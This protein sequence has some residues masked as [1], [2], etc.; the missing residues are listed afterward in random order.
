MKNSVRNGSNIIMNPI[1]FKRLTA[2]YPAPAILVGLSVAQIIA[3]FQVYGS[4]SALYRT[5]KAVH[6]AGYVTVADQHT[7]SRLQELSTALCGGLFL[8][9]S[10]GAGICVLSFLAAWVWVRVFRRKTVSLIPILLI[11]AGLAACFNRGGFSLF[12]SLYVLLVPPVVFTGTLKWMP[13]GDGK[14]SLIIGFM[15]AIPIIV[16]GLLWAPQMDKALFYDIRDHLLRRNPI[17]EKIVDFYYRY[18]FYPAQALKPLDGKRFKTYRLDAGGKIH[19]R[20]ELR[21]KLF[22][23]GFIETEHA[24][25]VDLI[26]KGSV[27]EIFLADEK[28]TTFEISSKS[29]LADPEAALRQFSRLADRNRFFRQFA[30]YA[31]LAGFPV[32]LYILFYSFYFLFLGKWTTPEMGAFLSATLCF[33]TALLFLTPL[34]VS[35]VNPTPEVST[36]GGVLIVSDQNKQ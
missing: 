32:T 35:T 3:T 8:T 33:L 27:H 4:N 7:I 23:Q 12:G 16:L 6:G 1:P 30:F 31:L 26:L 34:W 5:V 10:V 20:K 24:E 28:G 14:K 15:Q 25:S 21:E 17:G 29:F 22:V 19:H 9:L 18:T 2:C 36:E 11:W 13:G